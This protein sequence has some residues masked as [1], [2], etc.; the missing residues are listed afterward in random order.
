MTAL[1]DLCADAADLTLTGGTPANGTYSGTGVSGGVFSAATAGVGSY[2]IT[3][4]YTDAN[5]CTNLDSVV[6][7]VNAL[8][9]VSF[10]GLAATYCTNSLD[11]T[12]VP[13]PIGG[14]FTGTGMNADVFSA[15][16]AG[17]GSFDISYSYTDGNG[18][19]S[20][21]TNSTVV[22]NAPQVDLGSDTTLCAIDSTL[23]DAGASMVSYVW[24]TGASSQSIYA[25]SS[26]FGLGTFTY[27]VLITDA[28]NCFVTDSV[29]ITFEALPVSQ[30]FD[31]ST[32][33]G[34]DQSLTLDAG[35]NPLYGYLWS[36][37][38]TTNAIVVDT[39]AI[40]GTS[41]YVSVTLTS[42]AGCTTNDSSYVYF[43]EVPMPF[44]GNDST[45]CWNH[46]FVLD[47]GAG[48]TSYLWSTG[49]TTQTITLDSLSFIIGNNDYSVEVVNAV[50]CANSDTMTLV[51]DPCT[52]L[53]TQE[54][55]NE[56]FRVYPNPSKGRFQID[57]TGLEN[58]DYS[59]E[60]FNS[61][62]SKVAGKNL[63]SNGK[64]SQSW[65][66]DLSTYAKGIY[67]VRLQAVGKIKVK[68]III[69]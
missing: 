34:E 53:Y 17:A 39:A 50:N 69:Q 2:Y 38:A 12:L 49:A 41:N 7:T 37:G 60:I 4:S 9:V 25:D 32:I 47:A 30:L 21:D 64:S 28:N 14:I 57:I 54:L 27:A 8:P 29:D 66:V 23:L 1:A 3:Y 51:V 63:D 67:F 22:Y 20:S 44:I 48:Y 46:K 10:T 31:T 6:Q 62:G 26:D 43:R 24:N 40:G 33:C 42:P 52:G 55:T 36:T 35:A 45:I 68:R 65:D 16:T 56:D 19:S 18:C 15:S 59:I 11:D 61:M 13:N 58:E 5:S